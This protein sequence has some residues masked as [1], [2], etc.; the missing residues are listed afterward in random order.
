[1][2]I[3][4]FYSDWLPA[5]SS[6]LDSIVLSPH[7]LNTGDFNFATRKEDYCDSPSLLCPGDPTQFCPFGSSPVQSGGTCQIKKCFNW[8]REQCSSRRRI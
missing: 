5:P 3:Q 6:P 8:L 2:Q 7:T 1:M 4:N